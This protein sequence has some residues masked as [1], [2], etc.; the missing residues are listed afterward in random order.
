MVGPEEHRLFAYR[1]LTGHRVPR[2]SRVRILV[3][4]RFSTRTLEEE[5]FPAPLFW[6]MWTKSTNCALR[7]NSWASSLSNGAS[8]DAWYPCSVL[9]RFCIDGAAFEILTK[10][11]IGASDDA[12]RA[13]V[14]R[15]H[16][17][18]FAW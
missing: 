2:E 13:E 8:P 16:F 7:P 17:D 1:L 14:A 12:G 10:T 3:M 9:P 18:K 15:E 11:V 6:S 4:T 5:T